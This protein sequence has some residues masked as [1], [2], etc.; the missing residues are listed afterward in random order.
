M[1]TREEMGHTIKV[2]RVDHRMTQD[3]LGILLGYAPHRAGANVRKFENGVYYPPFDKIRD[4]S[5]ILEIPL[6]KLIP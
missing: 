1:I 5:R 3:E 2:A 4:L 6:D